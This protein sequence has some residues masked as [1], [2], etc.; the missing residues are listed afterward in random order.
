MTAFQ[1]IF[2]AKEPGPGAVRSRINSLPTTPLEATDLTE[3]VDQSL[4]DTHAPPDSS[5]MGGSAKPVNKPQRNYAT[6]LKVTGWSSSER[7][8]PNRFSYE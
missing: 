5:G 2:R 3:T 8:G 1:G 6:N 7:P 4:S